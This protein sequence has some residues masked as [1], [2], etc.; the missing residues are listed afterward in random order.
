MNVRQRVKELVDFIQDDERLREERK[1]AKKNKDKYIGVSSDS[2]GYGS[3]CKF[4]LVEW[5]ISME[6]FEHDVGVLLTLLLVPAGDRY[7]SSDTRGRWDNDWE[8]NK[9]PFPFSDK[10]GEIS[11]KIGSTIDDTISR[12]RKKER[13]DSPDRFRLEFR[14]PFCE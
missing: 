4:L 2:M 7:D 3:Y 12:F 9:G 1:K 14:E 6:P 10:L 5:M 8:K 11:D 13:D